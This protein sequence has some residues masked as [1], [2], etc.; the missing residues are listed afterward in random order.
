MVG[1]DT[2]TMFE[3]S[4]ISEDSTEV[5]SKGPR[6]APVLFVSTIEEAT[7]RSSRREAPRPRRIPDY[8]RP[9]VWESVAGVLPSRTAQMSRREG[10]DRPARVS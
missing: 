8:A 9:W 1:T 3:S 10:I 2:A 6:R 4:M 7:V 5:V